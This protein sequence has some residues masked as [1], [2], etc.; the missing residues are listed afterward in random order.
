MVDGCT[1]KLPDF[2]DEGVESIV[3][4]LSGFGRGLYVGYVVAVRHL[5]GLFTLHGPCL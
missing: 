2:S 5:F 1:H 3:D 4:S